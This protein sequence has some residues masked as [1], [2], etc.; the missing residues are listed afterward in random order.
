[1]A[2]EEFQYED[3][4]MG[5]YSEEETQ[6]LLESDEISPEEEGF[7]QGY[8]NEAIA[9]CAFCHKPLVDPSSVVERVIDGKTYRFCSEECAEEFE[10]ER[11]L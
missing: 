1:M 8:N 9:K 10:A 7:M 6:E 11:Q 2:E 3:E 4:G 5:V